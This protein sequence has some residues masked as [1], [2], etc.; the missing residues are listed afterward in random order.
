MISIRY[1]NDGKFNQFQPYYDLMTNSNSS[2]L[3]ELQEH[4]ISYL[5]LYQW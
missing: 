2:N 1:Q 4:K 5:K 3:I